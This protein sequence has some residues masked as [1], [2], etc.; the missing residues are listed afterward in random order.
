MPVRRQLKAVIAGGSVG[1]LFIGHM[2][3][4]PGWA[5]EIVE[6]A[7]S[8]LEARGAGIAGHSELSAILSGIGLTSDR[9][10]GIDVSGRVAFDRH[11]KQLAS[12][13]Y[14]QYLTS[15]S[16]VF[17]LLYSAFP[18]LAQPRLPEPP[19]GLGV[20]RIQ[21]GGRVQQSFGG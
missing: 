7:A 18:S 4:Q 9:P 16:S 8:G 1:G 6:R 11:G 15:W 21:Y 2:L 13:D 3:L 14:P 10:P 19:Q 12:F 17:N 20:A 5:V